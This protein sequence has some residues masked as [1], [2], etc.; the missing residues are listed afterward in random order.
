MKI[1]K[2]EEFLLNENTH[3]IISALLLEC[4]PGYPK[5]RSYFK[6]PPTFR[7]L[8]WEKEA[9]VGHMGVDYRLISHDHELIPI[10]G[11]MDLCVLPAFQHRRLA[12]KLL[13]ELEELGK[14]SGVDFLLLVAQSLDL[15]LNNG[16][17]P[18]KNTCQ[19][20]LLSGNQSLG[21]VRRS[22][23]DIMVKP[24]QQKEWPLGMIDFMGPLF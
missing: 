7:Y 20:L 11:I 1:E 2:T 3:T 10:F 4:F 16:F 9:L 19:W 23:A 15:Y 21:L 14:K 6:H 18:V 5:G 13:I 17:L 22:I 12:S 24:L 8:I